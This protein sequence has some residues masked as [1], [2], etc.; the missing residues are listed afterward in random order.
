MPPSSLSTTA[1]ALRVHVTR[2]EVVNICGSNKITILDLLKDKSEKL[3]IK[4]VFDLMYCFAIS[5]FVTLL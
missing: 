2:Q 1:I 4:L 5:F 3:Y